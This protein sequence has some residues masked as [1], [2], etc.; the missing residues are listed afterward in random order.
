MKILEINKFYYKESGVTSFL[1]DL[2]DLFKKHGHKIIIFS[3]KNK[4]NQKSEYT[5]YFVENLDM[6]E[7]SFSFRKLFRLFYSLQ[8]RKR[9]KKIIIQEKPDIV[10]IHNIY[11]HISP[12]ILGVIKKFNIPIVMSVH[13]YKLIC[14]NYMLFTKN[15]PCIRCK[16]YKYYNAVFNKC[17]KN[18]LGGSLAVCLEMYFHK[19]FRFY[20]RY[21]DKF[22][23]PSEFVKNMLINFGQDSKKIIVLPHYNSQKIIKNNSN[24]LGD[25]LLFF[26]RLSTEKGIDKLI[27]ALYNTGL[28]NR[29]HIVGKGPI[30]NKLQDL[31]KE[32]GMQEQVSFLGMLEKQQLIRQIAGARL[33]VVP[34]RSYETFGL[35][36]M[37]SQINSK[38]VLASNVGAMKERIEH[39]EN[40]FLFDYKKPNDF[41]NKLKEIVNNDNI[42]EKVGQQARETILKNYDE[43]EY[44][45]KIKKIFK[46][47]C[48]Q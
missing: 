18:S 47:L 44:Y 46:D 9:V 40:G 33:V 34:S 3:M 37:E 41:E 43:E 6:S 11:H 5:K 25:Y 39:S 45:L 10:H 32:K 24:N 1:F 38:V 26:G 7:P 19:L 13:D 16:K 22:I 15:M 17:M 14:P 4:R 42:L 27:N 28:K 30:K 35:T 2:I 23:V 12:S 29:L 8:A 31:V 20:E 36:V 48:E 21:V